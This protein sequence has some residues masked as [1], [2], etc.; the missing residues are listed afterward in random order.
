MGMRHPFFY[1]GCPTDHVRLTAHLAGSAGEGDIDISRVTIDS[2]VRF[3]DLTS[4]KRQVVTLT[5]PSHADPS[6]GLI[7]ILSPLGAALFSS[8][9]KDVVN[10]QLLGVER[11]LR[12]LDIQR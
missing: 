8:A 10:V 2:T 1:R 3:L 7:S 12:V 5:H 4:G 9:V 11:K 6:A